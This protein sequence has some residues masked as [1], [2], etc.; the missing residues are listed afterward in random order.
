MTFTA[1]GPVQTGSL[2]IFAEGETT[3]SA[4]KVSDAVT[5]QPSEFPILGLATACLTSC[6]GSSP[7][8]TGDAGLLTVQFSGVVNCEFDSAT[9]VG[10]Y[11]QQSSGQNGSCTD[12]GATYPTNGA[13]VLGVVLA[14]Q[15][16]A[17][18]AVPMYL[19]GP[20]VLSSSGTVG[21]TGATGATGPQGPTG[22]NGS[23]GPTG[24]AGAEGATGAKGATGPSGPQGPTGANGSAGPTG[25]AGSAGAAGA[26][27]A[28]GA[29]G[30]GTVSFS[31]AKNY[32]A[33][34][35]PEFSSF[36]SGQGTSFSCGTNPAS[37]ALSVI[38]ES[39]A[40]LQ[41]LNVVVTEAPGAAITWPVVYS[42]PGSLTTSSGPTCPTANSAGASCSS[43]NTASVTPLGFM[44]LQATWSGTLSGTAHFAATVQ[45]H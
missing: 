6:S 16:S 26:T 27:G 10:D 25:S 30:Q 44:S 32:G 23:V 4:V 34:A 14:N 22:A 29:A 45:C 35:S 19:I 8:V 28:T 33:F 41:N 38:P 36:A 21:S 3:S 39:C 13:Q 40:I 15:P 20:E 37:C 31:V 42:S 43:S 1:L 7:I 2:V 11:V 24:S 9:V 5:G 12:A 18:Q 17:G